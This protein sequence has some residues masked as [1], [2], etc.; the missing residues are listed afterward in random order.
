MHF[1]KI[2]SYI[3]ILKGQK[4]DVKQD[5]I[6]HITSLQWRLEAIVETRAKFNRN[7]EAIIN[8]KIDLRKYPLEFQTDPQLLKEMTKSLEQ[9]FKSM[10]GYE[11]KKF[12]RNL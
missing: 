12:Q 5:Y 4:L 2:L 3:Y 10:K 1:L 8:V 11:A 6:N 7:P 9:A